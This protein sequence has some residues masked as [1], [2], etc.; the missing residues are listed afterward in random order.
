MKNLLYKE[1]KLAAHPTTYIFLLLCTM[2]L[3]P[4]YPGYVTF[5][6]ICLSIFFIFLAGRENKDIFYTALLPVRKRD[7]VKARCLMIAIIELVQIALAAPLAVLANHLYHNAGNQAGIDL[8][9]AFF[10]SAFI[11]FAVFN[12]TFLPIFYRSAYKVGTALLYGGIAIFVYYVAA[13]MLVWVPSPVSA[14]LDTLNPAAMLRQLPILFAGILIWVVVTF[15]A[16]RR[17]AANF[18]KVD[19]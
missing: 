19:L 8:N 4:N 7:I 1:F 10:G 12:I 2:M 14:F 13:E 17:A 6:Y 16:Y 3:I 5:M 18:E 9:V 15:L 11:F